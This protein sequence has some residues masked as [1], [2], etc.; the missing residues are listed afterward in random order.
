MVARVLVHGGRV[1]FSSS[2]WRASVWPEREVILGC[3]RSEFGHGQK[4]KFVHL[5]LL[6]KLA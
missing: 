6:Y 3:F 2:T 1:R 4:M 5:G